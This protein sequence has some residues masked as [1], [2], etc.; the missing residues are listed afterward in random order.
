MINKQKLFLLV[1]LIVIGSIFFS[2][3]SPTEVPIYVLVLPFMYLFML[4]YLLISV[5]LDLFTKNMGASIPMIVSG[6]ILLMIILGS[7]HQLGVKDIVLSL[8]LML[9]LGWYILKLQNK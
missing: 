4:F 9:L 7:L 8:V 1:L 5:L 6:L 2:Y 3:T